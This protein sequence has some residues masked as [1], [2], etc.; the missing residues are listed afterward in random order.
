[1]LASILLAKGVPLRWHP[2]NKTLIPVITEYRKYVLKMKSNPVP[3]LH[4]QWKR[5]ASVTSY[6]LKAHQSQEK[7]NTI[8]RLQMAFPSCCQRPLPL[9]PLGTRLMTFYMVIAF[10]VVSGYHKLLFPCMKQF[11]KASVRRLKVKIMCHYHRFNLKV[12][13][14]EIMW[15]FAMLETLRERKTVVFKT[16]LNALRKTS[17]WMR[18]MGKQITKVIILTKKWVK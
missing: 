7:R 4:W 3:P 12:V 8:L 17:S 9:S 10:S 13:C 15:G 11:V 2:L 5:Q 16:A 18:Q 6:L 1:M 14:L